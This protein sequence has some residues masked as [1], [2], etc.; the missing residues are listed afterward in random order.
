[1][2][3]G[4]LS[5]TILGNLFGELEKEFYLPLGQSGDDGRGR[6]FGYG[7]SYTSFKFEEAAKP[8]LTSFST[9]SNASIEFSVKVRDAV[10]VA[11]LLL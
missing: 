9:G 8:S 3:P 2:A 7:L 10:I 1:M 6:A 5:V 11:A 4:V